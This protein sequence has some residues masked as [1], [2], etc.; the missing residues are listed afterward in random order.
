MTS[1]NVHLTP[2]SSNIKT[3]K[4]PVSTSSSATCPSCCPFNNANEGGCYAES[5]PL[6]LHWR[7]VSEGTR[8]SDWDV[9]CATIASLPAGVSLWRHN[10]AGDL[11]GDG[12][13]IDGKALAQLVEANAHRRGFT[14]SHYNVLEN[15]ANRAIIEKANQSNFTINLSANNLA[16]ADQLAALNIGPVAVVLPSDHKGNTTTPEGRRVVEC[17]AISRD[18]V[19]CESCG[20]C[21]H[22]GHAIV[23]FPA[24]GT[25]KRKASTVARCGEKA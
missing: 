25:Q 9:F 11:P 19:T 2:K 10:Q 24:H 13:N 20:M 6:A 16:H 14:Y 17:P 4:I 7:K 21:A 3:G 18:D 12:E 1:Y 15:T 8:G 5:G 23:G 22:K